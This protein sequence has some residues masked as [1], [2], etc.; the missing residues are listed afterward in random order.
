MTLNEKTIAYLGRIRTGR[1]AYILQDAMRRG[2][3]FGR[4]GHRRGNA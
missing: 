3:F 2:P 1:C 4:H